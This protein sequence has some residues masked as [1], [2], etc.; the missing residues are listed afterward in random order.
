M[1]ENTKVNIW[2]IRKK[3]MACSSGQ[4]EESTK[5]DGKMESSMGKDHIP[6]QMERSS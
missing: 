2:T 3:D 4:M 6:Q 5:E 1:V